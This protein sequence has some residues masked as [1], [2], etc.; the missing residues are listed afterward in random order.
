[1]DD[2]DWMALKILNQERNITKAAERLYVSQPTLTYRIQHLEKELGIK[3]LNRKSCGPFFTP[4]GDYMVQ[5]AN[6]MLEK[7][8]DIIQN[9]HGMESMVTGTLRLGASTVFAQY[10][11]A[12][13]LK[14]YK[15]HFPGVEIFLRTG[16]STTILPELLAKGEVD[17][18]VLRGDKPWPE[19]KHLLFADPFYIIYSQAIKIDQLPYTPWIQHAPAAFEREQLESWW[20]ERFSEWPVSSIEV[21]KVETSVQMVLHGLGWTILP[22]IYLRKL[23]SL[24]VLPAAKLDGQ[25][26]V[27][28]TWLLYQNHALDHPVNRTFIDYIL[29]WYK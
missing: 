19:S 11:L 6:A 10:E 4:H 5:Y 17:V 3:L 25:P 12:V 14:S 8:S 27:R 2:K 21:D 18:A 29:D 1:M 24:F 13:I 26:L 15:E 23:H 7:Y 9:L 20:H 22:R 16:S 28:N